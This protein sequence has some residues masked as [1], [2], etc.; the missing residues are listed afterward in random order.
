LLA[1]VFRFCLLPFAFFLLPSSFSLLP[2]DQ[3]P[4]QPIIVK[5]VE[6]P[7]DPTGLAAVLIGALGLTGAIVLIAVLL[8]LVMAG[9]L[10][11]IRSRSA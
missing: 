11:W 5:I 6:P 4:Q 1:I 10:F 8:G 3:Q 9:V 2:S 7:G